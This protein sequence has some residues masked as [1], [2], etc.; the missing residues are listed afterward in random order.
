ML[1]GVAQIMIHCLKVKEIY[2]YMYFFITTMYI[3]LVLSASTLHCPSAKCLSEH[4]P[5]LNIED[6]HYNI[7]VCSGAVV[8]HQPKKLGKM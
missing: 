4:K 5:T 6:S 1:V 2:Y 8:E 3:H 7:E